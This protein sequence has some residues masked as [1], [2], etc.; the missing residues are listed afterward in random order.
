MKGS[1][2]TRTQGVTSCERIRKRN[3][4]KERE[5]YIGYW[6]R[7]SLFKH[8]LLNITDNECLLCLIISYSK[9]RIVPLVLGENKEK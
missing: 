1:K 4:T 3:I 5:Q 6:G 2:A 9:L 7:R 8:I